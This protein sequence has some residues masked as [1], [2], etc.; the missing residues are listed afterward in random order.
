MW[1]EREFCSSTSTTGRPPPAYTASF[2][3]TSARFIDPDGLIEIEA[4][5]VIDD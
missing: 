4:D 1:F 2:S 5:A 3:A